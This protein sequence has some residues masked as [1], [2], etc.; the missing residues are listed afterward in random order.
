MGSVETPAYGR[1]LIASRIDELARTDPE[2][3]WV[4]IPSA[5]PRDGFRDITWAA[6]ANAINCAAWWIKSELGLGQGL[7]TI[8]Y[9]GPQ[10]IRYL[11]ILVAAIKTG[12]VFQHVFKVFPELQE[13]SPRDLYERHPVK[14]DHWRHIGRVDDIL[15]FS[16]GEK[17]MPRKT[18]ELLAKHPAILSAL[19]CGH[20]RFHAAAILEPREYPRTE[21]DSE[22]L[23]DEIWEIVQKSNLIVPTH[24]VLSKSHLMLSSAD[25]PF[26]RTPKGT[27]RRGITLESYAEEIGNLY[28]NAEAGTT[29]DS[30]EFS[31]K[32]AILRLLESNYQEGNDSVDSQEK[33]FNA[34]VEEYTT[35]RQFSPDYLP[36]RSTE[37]LTVL[38][39]GST[40]SLG[41]YLLDSLLANPKVE[42]IYCLNRSE[43]ARARQ[44]S[45]NTARGLS[46]D[47]DK[48]TFICA[49]LAKPFFALDEGVYSEMLHSVNYVVHNQWQVDF[50]L[51]L[52]SFTPQ[53]ASVRTLSEFAA[54]SSHRAPII[55]VSSVATVHNWDV[56]TRGS[57]I[58][59]TSHTDD[60]ALCTPGY[61]ESKLAAHRI[62]EYAA[63]HWGIRAAILRVGQIAGPVTKGEMGM[64][65]KHEWFPSL[66]AS[67]KILGL[68]PDELDAGVS[69]LPVDLCARIVLE[70]GEH[71]LSAGNVN[72]SEGNVKYYHVVN[73]HEVKL[74]DLI[75][76]VQAYFGGGL[77]MVSMG[78]WV[79]ALENSA[80]G[81][82]DAVGDNPALKL[83]GF[84]QGL[85][86]EVTAGQERGRLD[87]EQTESLSAEMRGLKGADGEWMDLWLKQWSF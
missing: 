36:R 75:P 86:K 67:S 61:G 37:T 47:W 38:L 48:V 35:K 82:K 65:P 74:K 39:T 52:A 22:I 56:K 53:L 80:D 43:S 2:R 70:L 30:V 15:V 62:L 87:T 16:N 78:R 34:L 29:V 20:G 13:F 5:H 42:K 60:L 11:I 24:G 31:T 4:S 66:I 32:T 83:L 64:W 17:L 71:T 57:F 25:K 84:F 59:S 69:F 19:V 12:Y 46:T 77:G 72:E 3:V 23:L 81:E 50:N 14:P 9:M 79:E 7:P 63:E 33:I 85:A 10:D 21:R 27:L 40:G 44:T 41:S 51:S 54:Q 8:A 45:A 6:G 68:L 28:R 26:L 73:P 1:R 58:P 55:F 76:H 18:E 49:D